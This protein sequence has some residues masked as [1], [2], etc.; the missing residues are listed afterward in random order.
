MPDAPDNPEST[1]RSDSSPPDAPVGGPERPGKR[2]SFLARVG[3]HVRQLGADAAAVAL[4]RLVESATSGGPDPPQEPNADTEQEFHAGHRRLS[5]LH[6]VT[7]KLRGAADNYI[8][9]KLDEIEARVD[10]KLDEIERRIDEKITSLHRQVREMR[11]QELRHRLRLLKITLIFTVI[12]A[13]LSLGYKWL[14]IVMAG[15]AG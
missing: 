4:G 2:G 11:D 1:S 14:S 6:Q 5:A 3:E 9:V 10:L 13:L 8:T 7:E 12:V 15:G